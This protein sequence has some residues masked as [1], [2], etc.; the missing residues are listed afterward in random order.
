MQGTDGMDAQLD[1]AA[2][3]VA[4]TGRVV[5]FTGAGISTESGIP[6]FRSPT[7]LWARYDPDDFSFPNFMRSDSARRR[8]WTV[9]RELYAAIRAAQPNAAHQAI[10][11]LERLGLLDCVITQNVD[12]LHQRAGTDPAKVIELH[13]N[14]TR[15]RCLVCDVR[16]SRDEIQARL[17]AGEAVPA[18][19]ACGGVLKPLTVLFGEPMPDGAVR[20]AEERS[21]T[22]GCF[23]VVGSSLG[24][25]PAAYMP[26]HAKEAGARLVVV[27]LT[28]TRLDHVADVILAGPAASI[29][30]ALVE[31]VEARAVR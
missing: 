21:R 24:V 27:N 29:L 12:D 8:Y 26:S 9:G 1:R 4:T 2:E 28:P 22:A 7:G 23:L 16:Y 14:A 5:V 13:G 6:D 11:A 3:M 10:V 17:V 30:A 19:A 18:C 20:R 31:R 25:Y 15:V